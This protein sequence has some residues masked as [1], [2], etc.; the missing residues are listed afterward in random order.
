M[1]R[2]LAYFIA[3]SSANHFTFIGSRL[4]VALYASHLQASPAVVGLIAALFGVVSAFVCVPA[5]RVM[6]RIGPGRP[7]LWCSVLMSAGAMAG[8]IWGDIAALFIVSVVLGTFYSLFFVGH[9]QWVGKIG[10]S[11]DRVSNISLAYLGFSIATFLGPMTAGYVIDHLGYAA[12][13][14]MLGVVPL[15]SVAVLAFKVIES[16]PGAGQSAAA[17]AAA[18]KHRIADLLR[19]R[20][21]RRVY[22]MCV[23]ASSTWSI[24]SLLIPLYGSEIGLSASTI[25][26]ILGAYSFASIVIRVFMTQLARRFSSWQQMLLSLGLSGACFIVLPL[27]S[28]VAGLIVVAFL[29][30]LGMGLAGPLSQNLL[31]DASPP[32]RIGEV[33]GLRVTVMNSTATAVPLVSGALS[34]AV[35]VGPIF[36]L[37]AVALLGGSYMRREQ[38]RQSRLQQGRAE[39]P[40]S[41]RH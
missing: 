3:I 33:M 12:A 29:I 18:G 7:M 15:F 8:V 34:A 20:E 11:Q 41:G 24:V 40:R 21:L 23:I 30:G 22:L 36:W 1:V 2:T 26:L 32:E 17:G 28:N 31:Y 4:V 19:D 25:G 13:L 10:T 39:P 38:W 35:G 14:L 5:G 37:L 6:D 16:P 9:T 27:V